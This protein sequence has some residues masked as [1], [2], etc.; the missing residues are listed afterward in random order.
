MIAASPS[1]VNRIPI[2]NRIGI[3]YIWI[4]KVNTKIRYGLGMVVAIAL[5]K[6]QVN[7]TELGNRMRV[8]AK[9]LR[10]LAGSLEKARLIKS[11]QGVYG[12]YLLNKKPEEIT[13]DM[14]L[15]AFGEKP[16]ISDCLNENGCPQMEGC[17]IRPVWKTLESTLQRQFLAI[18]LKDILENRLAEREKQPQS[19]R[20][21]QTEIN[22]F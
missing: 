6:S 19:G 8:S 22:K 15:K 9:Y 14:I 1:H 7:T 12:G 4:M 21:R 10:K 3:N 13:I 17:L 11:V 2:D 5:E 16:V 20:Q 18:T